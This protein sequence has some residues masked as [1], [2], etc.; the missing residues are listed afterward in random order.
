VDS[1]KRFLD[2]ILNNEILIISPKFAARFGG[3]NH[4]WVNAVSISKI[5]ADKIATVLPF[6]MFDRAWPRLAT[7][8]DRVTVGTEG[9]IFS[10]QHRNWSQYV[11]LLT[12]ED[13]VKDRS[14]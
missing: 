2:F 3:H 10:Q 13:A 11:V 12:M 5:G 9:W 6:N 7:P 4:R 1:S 8:G 14:R